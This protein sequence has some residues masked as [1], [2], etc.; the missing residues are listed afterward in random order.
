[1]FFI[2]FK[3]SVVLFLLSVLGPSCGLWD[4]HL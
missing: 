2:F 3:K 1:M 4:L